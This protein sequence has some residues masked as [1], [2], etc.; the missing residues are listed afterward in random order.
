MFKRAVAV[1]VLMAVVIGLVT[2]VHAQ[3]GR[4]TFGRAPD[5]TQSSADE[6]IAA[7]SMSQHA[8]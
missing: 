7:T 8:P 2:F 5:V 6:Q 4:V 1:G 3:D